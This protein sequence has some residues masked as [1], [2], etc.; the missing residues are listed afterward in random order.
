M[1]FGA[2][3]ALAALN[4]L[5]PQRP[6][7]G[8]PC[9]RPASALRPPAVSPNELYSL[10]ARRRF[11]SYLRLRLLELREANLERAADAVEGRLSLQDLLGSE[12]SVAG[13]PKR[14]ITQQ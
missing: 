11:A 13:C 1:I 3:V 14:G 9:E 12:P 4:S 2:F 8:R 7:A 6:R 5:T 10:R